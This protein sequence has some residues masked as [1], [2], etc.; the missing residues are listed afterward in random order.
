MER[1]RGD[2][3]KRKYG[4]R[5]RFAG[6]Y[7]PLEQRTSEGNQN[8]DCAQQFARSSGGVPL[9][10]SVGVHIEAGFGCLPLGSRTVQ[11]GSRF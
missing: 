2:L 6:A 4:E 8:R 7:Q 11:E 3:K 1:F 5:V 9:L 10:L